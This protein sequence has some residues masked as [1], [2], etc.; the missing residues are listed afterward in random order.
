MPTPIEINKPLV[1][2]LRMS[3]ALPNT[4]EIGSGTL[5]ILYGEHYTPIGYLVEKHAVD[6]AWE[7]LDPR[8]F[9]TTSHAE[10]IHLLAVPFRELPSRETVIA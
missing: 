7:G 9:I 5:H 1:A 8:F 3:E 2:A 10:A 6:D 4:Q